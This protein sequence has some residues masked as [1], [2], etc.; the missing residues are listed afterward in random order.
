MSIKQKRVAYLYEAITAG[1]IRGAADKLNVAPSAISRHIALLEEELACKLIERHRTGI[2]VTQAGEIVL[3][4]YLETKSHEESCIA[5]L[6]ALQGLQLGHIKLVI[7]EGFVND[8]MHGPLSAFTK[9]FPQLT[10]SITLAG[11]NE[12]IRQIETDEAHIGLLFHP[13]NHPNIRSHVTR[14]Q[15]IC[16][17]VNPNHPLANSIE[18]L[19]LE[20]LLEY[21]VALSE[22][23]FGVRQ[24]LA[25]AEFKQRLHF[26]PALTTNSIAV[27]KQFVRTD[28]GITFLPKFVITSEIADQQL[29]A[30][31]LADDIL[32]SG[33]THIVTRLGR[34]LPNGAQQL[35]NHL[36]QWMKAFQ[37]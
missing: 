28:M 8:L 21:P 17:V 11:T 14:Q 22:S 25:L 34:Q 26:T 24:L 30:L 12:V 13:A 15:P 23:S 37:K 32:N 1:S 36:M 33:E 10:L 5:K 7:G 3:H 19:L 31:P 4:Y 18:P 9:Q 6:S 2:G 35:L 27:L 29:V 20:A 16:A